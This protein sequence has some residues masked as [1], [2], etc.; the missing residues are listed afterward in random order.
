MNVLKSNLSIVSK[1]EAFYTGGRIQVS[2]DGKHLFC[3]C[4]SKVTILETETGKVVK[5]IGQ[6]EDEEVS[7]FC[8]SPDD[9]HLVLVTRTLLLRQWDWQAGMLVRTWRA[10]HT[11]PVSSMLFDGTSTLLATGGSDATIKVWDVVEQYCTHNFKGHQGVISVM[12]FRPESSQV[13]LVSA[14]DDYKVRVWDLV[15]SSCVAIMDSHYSLITSLVFSADGTAMYSGGRDSILVV[16]D[17]E[18]LAVRRTLPVFESVESVMLLRDDRD[19]SDL[20][21]PSPDCPHVLVASSKGN[22]RV[23]NTLTGRCV[24]KKEAITATAA[25]EAD[26]DQVVTQ[27]IHVPAIDSVVIVTYDQNIIFYDEQN[28]SVSKQLSGS[29]DEVL[30][31]Q[32]VGEDDTHLVVASNSAKLKVFNVSTWAC[33]IVEGHSDIVLAVAVYAKTGLVA[34]SSKDSTVR[35]WKFLPETG[36]LFCVAVCHGHVQAVSSVAFS[37]KSP[38]FIVS[39]GRDSTLKLW[40][41]EDAFSSDGLTELTCRATERGH[42][43]DINCITVAPNDKFI[44]TGSQDKT[45]KLWKGSNLSLAGVFRGHSRG[46]WCVQFSPVD[47]CLATS[48]TDGSVRIWSLSDL[49][50]LKT[51]EGHDASVLKVVFVSRGMQLLSVGSDG[52]L[53]LWTI[54][55]ND[56]VKTYDEHAAKVWCVACSQDEERVVTADAESNI[57]LWK[58]VS[59]QEGEEILLKQEQ[60]VLQQQE[61]S[62]LIHEKRYLKAIGLAI[63]LEQPY[64]ALTVMKEILFDVDGQKKLEETLSK[65]RPDQ[66]D[67][68][69]RFSVAWNTNS[70][71]CHLAQLL[72]RVVLQTLSPADICG[73]PNIRSTVEGLLPYT[74]R[75]FQRLTRLYQQSRFIEYTWQC[76]RTVGASPTAPHSSQPEALGEDVLSQERVRAVGNKRHRSRSNSGSGSDSDSDSDSASETN[77]N[78]ADVTEDLS[79]SDGEDE[80]V[81]GTKVKVTQRSKHVEAYSKTSSEVAPF[82]KVPSDKESRKDHHKKGEMAG[83]KGAKKRSNSAGQVSQQDSPSSRKKMKKNASKKGSVTLQTDTG[84]SVHDSPSSRKKMKKNASKKGSVTVQTDTDVS[85]L[86]SPSSRKKM[87]KNASKMGS[88]TVQTETDV[89]VLERKNGRKSKSESISGQKSK[90]TR[91]RRRQKELG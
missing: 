50:C 70:K 11:G 62:N 7:S 5:T 55:T 13:Q 59:E 60:Q 44:A 32:F 78:R 52:L 25:D 33:Q 30:D 85:V 54:K 20:D 56:C 65:L 46:V 21:L 49:S 69:L 26:D 57:I 9:K 39:G 76:S 22:I 36:S 29:A 79:H 17:M 31:V 90:T 51:F 48:S 47:Q 82:S 16:W 91:Q 74:E 10:V 18:K 12:A 53:K 86:D 40:P 2:N 42:E 15:T 3:P 88:V 67:A 89:S 4:S 84:D 23:I 37:R 71:H 35:L 8:V 34:T 77:E 28:L 63:T 61:L 81:Q 75:H 43:K 58:D 27:A 1:Y 24:H 45:A 14:A 83:S 73:L 68:I 80:I 19:Y 87:K 64:R 38:S 41:I 66:I 72:L 6:D